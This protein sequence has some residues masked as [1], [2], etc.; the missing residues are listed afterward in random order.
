MRVALIPHGLLPWE[1]LDER[2]W[3]V[4]LVVGTLCVPMGTMFTTVGT[5]SFTV[6]TPNGA[7]GSFH[8]L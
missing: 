3:R 7:V 6:G 5:F 1:D 8:G 2:P 4:V